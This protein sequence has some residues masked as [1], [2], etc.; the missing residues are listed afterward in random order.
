MSVRFCRFVFE[1]S[2]QALLWAQALGFISM[3]IGW[4]ANY[5]E[6]DQQLFSGNLIASCLTA[7]HL[8]LL[9]STLGMFNQVVNAM[10]FATCRHSSSLDGYLRNILPLL[11]SSIAVLQGFV[12][13]EHWSEW[14]A[15]ASAVLMSFALFHLK[16]GHLRC[17]MMISNVLSLTLSI[18]LLSWSG[19]LY[20]LVTLVILAHGLL[21]QKQT[22][23]STE[24]TA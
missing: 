13:A 17:A 10:R 19:I 7:I 5:Q 24:Q 3:A 16:G 20:Q 23:L 1:L 4:W 22:D 14:C 18:H 2:H 11:F 8:G 9:G 12:W 6:N 21:P 15:V